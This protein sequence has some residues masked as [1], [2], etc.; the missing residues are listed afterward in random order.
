M[1]DKLTSCDLIA[2]TIDPHAASAGRQ[3]NRADVLFDH[4]IRD[5]A[6]N[7]EETAAAG[8]FASRDGIAT[9]EAPGKRSMITV[10]ATAKDTFIPGIVDDLTLLNCRSCSE[11][12]NPCPGSSG[13]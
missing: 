4:A 9:H 12:R 2:V 11:A 1:A 6:A 8:A 5:R 3:S 13:R 7:D 10:H